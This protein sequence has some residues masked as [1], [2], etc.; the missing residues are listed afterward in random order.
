M[1]QLSDKGRKT[2]HINLNKRIDAA[3]DEINKITRKEDGEKRKD[4][5][6]T[7]KEK[8][9]INYL[10]TRILQ[11]QISLRLAFNTNWLIEQRAADVKTLTDKIKNEF[12]PGFIMDETQQADQRRTIARLNALTKAQKCK[13]NGCF[14][15]RGYT[16]LNI[17]TGEFTLCK[18]TQETINLY[19]LHD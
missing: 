3:V 15:A 13:R 14:T 2:L 17:S 10:Q 8:E 11:F 9:I 4:D 19:K 18:C 1:A 6:L 12:V 5:E 7:D 16:G